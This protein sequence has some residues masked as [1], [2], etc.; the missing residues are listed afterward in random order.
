MVVARGTVTCDCKYGFSIKRP[1]K[2]V[3]VV[4]VVGVAAAAVGCVIPLAGLSFSDDENERTIPPDVVDEDGFDG[5]KDV[6][7]GSEIGAANDVKGRDGDDD[8]IE[9]AFG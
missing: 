4:V 9:E 8:T 3:V 1:L 6:L 5:R 7:D 2:L